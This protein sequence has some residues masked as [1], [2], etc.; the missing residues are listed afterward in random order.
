[1]KHESK[2]PPEIESCAHTTYRKKSGT[3]VQ[4]L[5]GLA[6]ARLHENILR[7]DGSVQKTGLASY[8]YTGNLI[9]TSLLDCFLQGIHACLCCRSAHAVIG[10]NMVQ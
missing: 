3:L 7:R 5:M 1:M 9:P 4:K 10:N 6:M 2:S 8:I